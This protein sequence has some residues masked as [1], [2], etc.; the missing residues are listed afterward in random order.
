MASIS[1]LAAVKDAF[2]RIKS[3]YSGMATTATPAAPATQ[4]T[5]DKELT[6]LQVEQ[7]DLALQLASAHID[8]E[9]LYSHDIAMI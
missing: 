4:T 6:L 7:H 3:T 1:A 9:A 5:L 2:W 8:L